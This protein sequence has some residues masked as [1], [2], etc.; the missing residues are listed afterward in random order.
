MATLLENIVRILYDIPNPQREAHFH[1][2][3]DLDAVDAEPV[4]TDDDT[5]P[6]ADAEPHDAPVAAAGSGR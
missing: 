4:T 2:L 3:A 1:T 5:D 6:D